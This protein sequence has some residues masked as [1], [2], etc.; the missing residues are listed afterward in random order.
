MNVPHDKP[1]HL[2]AKPKGG[3]VGYA[4][5]RRHAR[6]RAAR[7]ASRARGAVMTIIDIITTIL[8]I[9]NIVLLV[10]RSVWNYPFGIA[11]VLVFGVEFYRARFYSDAAL[12]IFFF[13][14]QIYGWWNWLRARDADGLARVE[15]LSARARL[16]WL[17]V[18]AA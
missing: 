18:I 5:P 6:R 3:E 1:G 4:S 16:V 13:V 12:Q 10:R 11:L 7:A 17:A 14:V 9:A 15:I 2:K 8:G